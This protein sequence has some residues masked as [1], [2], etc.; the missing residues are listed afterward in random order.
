[1]LLARFDSQVCLDLLMLL[2]PDFIRS[3][4]VLA[5]R[6][7]ILDI[8]I[9]SIVHLEVTQFAAPALHAVVVEHIVRSRAQSSVIEFLMSARHLFAI[10]QALELIVPVEEGIDWF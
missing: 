4:F 3:Y 10:R 2:N 7:I 5:N 9:A 1:M 8:I 6:I